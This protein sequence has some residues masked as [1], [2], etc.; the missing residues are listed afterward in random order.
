MIIVLPK[1]IVGKLKSKNLLKK[2]LF[3]L[4][5][6][7][8]S[9]AIFAQTGKIVGKVSDSQ[10]GETLIGVSVKIA[11]TAKGVGTDVDGKYVLGGLSTGKYTLEISYLGYTTKKITDV[12]VKT[13]NVTTLNV[14]LQ[15][16]TSQTL[17][18]IVISG[19]YKQ[20]SVNS[21]LLQQKN[22][23]SIS[24]GISSEV[25]KKSPDKNTGEVLRRVSG[26]SMQDDKFIIVRGL[27]DRYN[28]A[29]INNSPLPSSEP[30]RKTFS[31][32]VIPSNLVDNVVISKTA[33][34]DL[35][36]EF[37]GGVVQIK[38]KDF[39]ETKNFEVNVGLGYN[40]IS[41]FNTFLGNERAITD[42][43]GFGNPDNKLPSDFP[44]TRESFVKLPL[45]QRVLLSK[46]FAN[47]WSIRNLKSLPNPSLQI[48]YGN[49]YRFKN[50]SKIGFMVSATYR[51]SQSISKE[52]RNDYN[53]ISDS[54]KGIPL[55]EYQDVYYNFA[56]GLGLLA[57]VSY[58]KGGSK[59]SLKNIYN[60]SFEDSYLHRTG[61][62]D[63]QILQKASQQEVIERSL[64]NSVLEGDHLLSQTSRAKL[65][66]NLS[67][68][69][70]TNEQPDLRRLTYSKSL[71][72]VNEPDKAYEAA[73]P[74]VAT[75]S[76]GGRFFSSLGENVYG[77]SI[78]YSL[79]INLFKQSHTFKVGLL[80]QNKERN[81]NA[82]VLGYVINTSDVKDSKELLALSQSQIFSPQNIADNKFYLDDIT[83]PANNYNGSG[84]LN[85]GYAMVNGKLSTHFKVAL[86]L[87]VE[88]YI[89]KLTTLGIAYAKFNVKNN[90][91]DF[92]PSVNLTYEITPKANFRLS[93]S[94]TIARA[95][96]RELASFSFYDFIIG[97]VK[98]G[99][100]NLKRT[101]ISNFDLRYEF[102][103]TAGQMLSVSAFYKKLKNPIENSIQS[104]STAA[105]R[106]ISYINAL[107][108]Y[109]AGAEFEIR[110]DLSFLNANSQFLKKLIYSANAA[111]IKS[112]VDF[113]TSVTIKNKRPLQG[114][115]SYLINT[116]LQYSSSS[117]W[118]TGLLYN[119]IGRRISVVGFGRYIGSNFIADYP[120]IYEAP[121]NLL[122][123]QLSKKIIKQKAE[124]KLNISN[125]LDSDGL[126]Y[127]DVND[128]KT[129]KSSNDQLI[130]SIKYGRTISLSF[131]YKF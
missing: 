27:S 115:S 30:D 47:T 9:A 114:Q 96:F 108:A 46:Q 118:Q 67:F 32:D 59:I 94:N 41:T 121:R 127:Q 1:P 74:L 45:G 61:I 99:N 110:H 97:T 76:T 57:N 29:M 39:P 81:V 69:Q 75:P 2:I 91:V 79:P 124:L 78:N 93:F 92:L 112:E 51:N 6:N 50:E 83:N 116:G 101:Q 119:R 26:A 17:K 49:S 65:S 128:D 55:F 56:T 126:F 36:G 58:A 109:I 63:L 82:R 103:P 100:P 120:D 23:V 64:L 117:G 10:T 106:S 11:G 14:V 16:A 72:A 122:D 87:R 125:I 70:I 90:Y 40:T 66:W 28:L 73:V 77:A 31:F 104:G 43:L 24:D 53:E 19:S 8:I 37:S 33:T 42:Y 48:V 13:D 89:E 20:E 113:G 35:S 98:M 85:A 3:T 95:Q 84:D 15:G 7:V 25:I 123:F 38:T 21:L 80:K 107:N 105:S 34:P 102:Y 129:Y 12:E 52:V 22:S 18:Q 44:S 111:L 88:N 60:Q 54:G 71:S 86:G 4:L 130:N 62:Y 5:F 131:G 68:S